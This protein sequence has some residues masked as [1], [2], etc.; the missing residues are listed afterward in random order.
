MAHV[1]E[2]IAAVVSAPGGAAVLAWY[3]P[4]TDFIV[5]ITLTD[6]T[7][8]NAP[9]GF[10]RATQ[11]PRVGE[12]R[13][14]ER[15]RVADETLA[16]VLR[17]VRGL[18]VVVGD[19]SD[20][21]EMLASL[22]SYVATLELGPEIDAQVWA[23]LFTAAATLY[24]AQPWET[25]PSDEWI[26]VDAERLGITGGALTVVGHHGTSYGF[27]LYRSADD[28]AACLDATERRERGEDA[29]FRGTFYMFSYDRRSELDPDDLAEISERRW[30]VAGPAAYPA[31]TVVDDARGRHPTADEIEGITAVIEALTAL[32]ADE[33][34]L[35]D[36]WSGDPVEWEG[37]VAGSRVRLAA[38]LD[39]YEAPADP[40]DATL[41]IFSDDGLVDEQLLARYRG[42][43]VARLAARDHVADELL[44]VAEMLVEFA[45]VYHS[46]TLATITAGELGALLL[47]TVPA[48]LAVDAAE[49]SRIVDA[50]RALLRLAA[51]EL[52]SDTAAEA[53]ATLDA[54]FT[55]RLARELADEANFAPGKQ[56]VMA[57]IAAGYDMSS[58]DGVAEFVAEFARAQRAAAPKPK[59]RAARSKSK[60]PLNKAPK[61]APTKKPAPAKQKKSAAAKRSPKRR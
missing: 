58:E 20:A 53:A 9:A 30:E 31:L 2:W 1:E 56:L 39:V 52:G 59:K 13:R 37:E 15:V 48:Q 44:P 57:G 28:A 21:R 46:T 40:A 8:E 45:A 5:D 23:R 16:A 35:A 22:G 7:F 29:K 18:E 3:E 55:V 6:A 42:A 12:P 61:K 33:P 27:M 19:I 51:D 60:T 49:A 25:I 4:E 50:A 34:D 54:A 10:V 14:P 17:Q 26:A 43:V 24:R 36:A 11:E 41:E 32:I 38:P 47:E